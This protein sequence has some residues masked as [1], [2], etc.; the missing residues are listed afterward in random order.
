MCERAAREALR[1]VMDP[2]LA[3]AEAAADRER[4]RE[5]NREGDRRRSTPS[6][7]GGVRARRGPRLGGRSDDDRD[8]GTGDA[9]AIDDLIDDDEDDAVSSGDS[10]GVEDGVED[11]AVAVDLTANDDAANAVDRRLTAEESRRVL[12]PLLRCARRATTRRRARTRP[13]VIKGGARA[14]TGSS[15]ARTSAPAGST[16]A[17]SCPCPRSTRCSSRSNA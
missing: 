11:D 5:R 17:R 2:A 3:R 16:A 1:R 8:G 13:R 9:F 4:N 6:R 7:R 12:V 10:P 14:P 15:R